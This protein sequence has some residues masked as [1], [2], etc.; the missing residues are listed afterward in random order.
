WSWASLFFDF[1]NDGMKDLFVTNG[2]PARMNDI[3]YVNFRANN[4]NHR[5][6]TQ[7]NRMEPED[8][9]IVKMIP[10][11]RL[12]NRFF[13]NSGDLRFKDVTSEI[14]NNPRTFSNGA[15]YVDIDGDGDLDVVTNNINDEATI[16]KNLASDR[17]EPSKNFIALKL[18]GPPKNR[19]AIGARAIVYRD[20]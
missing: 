2:I 17:K 9:E 8:L 1:D 6:K 19:D 11:I 3:D 14:K 16:Y 20:S 4:E 5:W 13:L 12:P 10:E 18:I 7:G 15:A